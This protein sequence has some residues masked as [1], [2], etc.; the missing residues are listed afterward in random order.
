M[1]HYKASM[2]TPRPPEEA[3]A[4]LSDFSTTEHWDPGVVSAERLGDGPVREGTEFALVAR[5]LG[6]DNAI[7]YRVVEFDA[8]ISVTLLGE[9]ASVVSLDRIT[10]EASGTGTKITYDARLSLK[11]PLRIAEPLLAPAFKRVG[12]R[13][14]EG[15]R[16]TIGEA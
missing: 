6:R 12:D 4:Y 11:G 2:H 8:P 3:F 14:L 15:L 10:C 1:A 13:A 7:V 5:F 16:R 9:N